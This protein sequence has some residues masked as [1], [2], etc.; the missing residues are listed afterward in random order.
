VRIGLVTEDYGP[1]GGAQA[2]HVAG[3]AR[4]ARRLGHA[5]RV[6]TGG[7]RPGEGA[8]RSEDVIR[9][10]PARTLLRR[11]RLARE[12]GGTGVGAA[13]REVLQRERFDV[14]HVFGPL[15]PVLPLLALHHASGPVIG[16]FHETERPGLL[17]RIARA[18]LQRHLDRLDAAIAVSRSA[19]AAAGGARDDLRVIPG[20]VDVDR[21]SRGR[22]LRR[23]EDGRLNVLWVGRAEPRNGLDT[24]IPAFARVRRQLDARLLVVGGGP[25]LAGYR[26][27][28]PHD[29]V[30]DVVFAGEVG[31]ELADWYASGDVFCAVA[32]GPSSGATLLEAMAAGKPVLASDVPGY[33]EVVQHGREGELVTPDDPA[34]WAR[35]ILRVSREPARAAT[36][37]ERGRLTARRLAWPSVAR[38][39]LGVYRA[40]GVR[41]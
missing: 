32:Q 19:A 20:G 35:A 41:G 18:T 2:A 28:I 39:I 36:Y 3:F 26:A 29:L 5:V 13:L 33:R 37:A 9:L 17:A 7:A 21:L 8:D 14:L 40:I 10:G 25:R 27:K 6:V 22:R 30:D 16:T 24:M 4:E 12:T 31:D 23:F 1:G 34:A 15:T 11:G 38:E